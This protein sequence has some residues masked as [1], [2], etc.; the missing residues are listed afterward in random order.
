MVKK[1]NGIK[2]ISL[3]LISFGILFIIVGTW[4]YF[5]PENLFL[6]GLWQDL[7]V[8]GAVFVVAGIGT[9]FLKRTM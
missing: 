7:F 3:T 6:F 8:A 2:K 4:G 9:L 1:K 5:T